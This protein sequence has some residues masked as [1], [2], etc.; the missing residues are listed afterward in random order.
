M[1][2]ARPGRPSDNGKFPALFLK[3]NNHHQPGTK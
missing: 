3:H 1:E 2:I